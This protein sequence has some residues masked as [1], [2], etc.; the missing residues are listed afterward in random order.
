M[1]STH[2]ALHSKT[3]NDGAEEGAGL[4]GP[5][6]PHSLGRTGVLKQAGWQVKM[7]E[8]YEIKSNRMVTGK[9]LNTTFQ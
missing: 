3:K 4:G 5:D 7:T 9:K 8:V 1:W 2:N 6:T